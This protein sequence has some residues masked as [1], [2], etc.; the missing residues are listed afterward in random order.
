MSTLGDGPR[1]AGYV[2]GYTITK[3]IWRHDVSIGEALAEGRREAGLTITQVSQ[4]TRIR[5]SIVRAVEQGDFSACGGDFYARGHIRSIAAAVGVDPAPLIR[6]YDE[7]HEPPGSISAAEV[8]EPSKPIRIKE[9][10]SFGLGKVMVAALLVVIGFA[11]YHLVSTGGS[12]HPTNTTGFTSA[13]DHPATHPSAS[14]K[15]SPTPKVVVPPTT[16]TLSI[17]AVENCWV[18]ITRTSGKLIYNGTIQAG[19]TMRWTQRGPWYMQLGN[20][21]GIVFRFNGKRTS[22]KTVQPI[23]LSVSPAHGVHVLGPAGAVAVP[24]PH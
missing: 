21:G 7:T 4:R 24:S 1:T 16:A 9:S 20:P 6:E 14:P 8:F 11:A 19:N 12:H 17:T 15:P 3:I 22:L 2:C 5:E 10:R 23:E 13:A 18:E